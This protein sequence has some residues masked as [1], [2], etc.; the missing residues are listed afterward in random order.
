MKREILYTMKMPYRQD[1][2]LEGFRFGEGEKS[3]AVVG[4][5]RG[6]EVQQMYTCARLVK[7][8]AE[9]EQRGN[10]LPGHE[11]LVI[12]CA[13]RFSMNVGKRFWPM[14]GSD[15]NRMFP[16]Y[17]LGETT[18]RIAAGL[19]EAVKDYRCGIHMAS[20]YL[21]GK[22]V[23]HARI[24]NTGYQSPALGSM[25]GLPYIVTREPKPIDTTTLNYNWQIWDSAAFNI[26]TQET[27]RLDDDSATN[28]V[29]AVLRYLS[30]VGAVKYTCYSGYLSTVI[31]ESELINVLT[32]AGGIFKALKAPGEE[33]R[34]GEVIGQIIDPFTAEIT[35]E[36]T[37]AAKSMVFF[38]M[39]KPL[40]LEHEIAFKLVCRKNG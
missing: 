32:P 36:I 28:A 11:I 37:A 7:T 8:L 33:V 38:A 18:Q 17:D 13:N 25:F 5:I 22:F 27:S 23:P 20:F 3:C 40:V 10:L 26:Y 4:G 39:E 35:H 15:I 31:S 6:D 21:P 30:R 12:P 24:V 2:L 34:R 9:I 29:D 1:F 19:F 14:D 16:G